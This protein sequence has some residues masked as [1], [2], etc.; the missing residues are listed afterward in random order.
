MFSLSPKWN[1]ALHAPSYHLSVRAQ[2]PSPGDA[3][4]HCSKSYTHCCGSEHLIFIK[5][6]V[7]LSASASK[8][9]RLPPFRKFWVLLN[10]TLAESYEFS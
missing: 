7:S 6:V 4:T 5:C 1:F 10:W 2:L 9:F 3:D 8:L